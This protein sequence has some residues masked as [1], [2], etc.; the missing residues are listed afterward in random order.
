M[1]EIGTLRYIWIYP[2]A[3][4]TPHVTLLYTHAESITLCRTIVYRVIIRDS[5]CHPISVKF[6][7]VNRFNFYAPEIEDVFV[8]S[9][10]LFSSLK[11]EPC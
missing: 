8:L 1:Y 9:V 2:I 7:V 5:T 4:D 10:I 11:L 6:L 3:T